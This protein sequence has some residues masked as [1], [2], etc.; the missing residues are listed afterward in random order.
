M[1]ERSTPT[2]MKLIA[3]MIIA[4]VMAVLLITAAVLL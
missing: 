1:N 3:M 2:T 4:V